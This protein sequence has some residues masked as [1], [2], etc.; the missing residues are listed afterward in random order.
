MA[1]QWN[2]QKYALTEI[3]VQFLK[4]LIFL[5][6][7]HWQWFEPDRKPFKQRYQQSSGEERILRRMAR[8]LR[9]TEDDPSADDAAADD[10]ETKLEPA[11]SWWQIKMVK[12]IQLRRKIGYRIHL[13][14]SNAWAARQAE[15]PRE[16]K[17]RLASPE[18]TWAQRAPTTGSNAG[19]CH[20]DPMCW[21][22]RRI[23]FEDLLYNSLEKC[24]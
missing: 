1:S 15:T 9:S 20:N 11:P 22:C 23:L 3:K 8:V 2:K 5:I 10:A 13:A 17:D 14:F 4:E 12:L 16:H 18:G 24:T 7:E 21:P 6:Q 19:F